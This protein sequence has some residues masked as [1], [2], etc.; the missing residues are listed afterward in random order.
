MQQTLFG[1]EL[2]DDATDDAGTEETE[3]DT[4]V[5]D[6][7]L[8]AATDTEE[9]AE[10]AGGDVAVEAGATDAGGTDEGEVTG[11]SDVVVEQ[12]V[13]TTHV[14][15]PANPSVNICKRKDPPVHCMGH[16][17]DEEEVTTGGVD[18]GVN[19]VGGTDDGDA[20]GT[21]DGDVGGTDDGPGGVTDVIALAEADVVGVD[22][23]G[24]P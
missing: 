21:D 15:L 18:D 11:I 7:T 17:D 16:V 20:G 5:T 23:P 8:D 6:V 9:T 22:D 1:I 12:V 4:D 13:G 24:A 19:G 10:D 3:T 2:E 14:A